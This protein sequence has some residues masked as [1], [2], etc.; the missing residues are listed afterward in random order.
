MG[1]SGIYEMAQSFHRFIGNHAPPLAE[2][3]S[4]KS[5]DQL[6]VVTYDVASN[7]MP[8]IRVTQMSAFASN[9]FHVFVSRNDHMGLSAGFRNRASGGRAESQTKEG[10]PQVS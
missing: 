6:P 9:R 1:F 2:P 7:Q 4:G 5:G 3:F 10:C 8:T